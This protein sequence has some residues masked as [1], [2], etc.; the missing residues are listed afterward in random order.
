MIRDMVAGAKI[1]S[2][3]EMLVPHPTSPSSGVSDGSE[4]C[5]GGGAEGCRIGDSCASSDGSMV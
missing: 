5:G 4:G 2:V 1:G 3:F